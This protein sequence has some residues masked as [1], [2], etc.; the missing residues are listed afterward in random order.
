MAEVKPSLEETTKKYLD[1]RGGV[2]IEHLVAV[3]KRIHDKDAPELESEAKFKEFLTSKPDVFR[4]AVSVNDVERARLTSPRR[5]S[6][7]LI[8]LTIS[9]LTDQVRHETQACYIPAQVYHTTDS[10]CLVQ[11]A[12]CLGKPRSRGLLGCSLPLVNR[13]C[14][15]AVAPSELWPT[16]RAAPLLI[17][18]TVPSHTHTR[19]LVR[20]HN[21]VST[22][23]CSE[24]GYSQK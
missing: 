21:L 6:K 1:R 7:G 9:V 14:I 23:S 5:A 12:R 11:L 16:I 19:S 22:S 18:H 2:V 20:W 15:S 3:L 24:R 13:V 17:Q 4:I 10:V 8:G